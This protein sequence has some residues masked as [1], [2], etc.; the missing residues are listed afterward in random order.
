[1]RQ[2]A[3]KIEVMARKSKHEAV[4]FEH[5]QAIVPGNEKMEQQREAKEHVYAEELDF[6]Q[7]KLELQQAQKSRQKPQERLAMLLKCRSL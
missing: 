2:L 6:E 7:K 3:S 5:K 1:M 4:V